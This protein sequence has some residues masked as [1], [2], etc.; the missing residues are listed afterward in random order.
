MQT[1]SLNIKS[2][3]IE[4]RPREKLAAKGRKSLT[5]VELLAI[6]IG[7][8]TGNRT[9][10]DLARDI[11]NLVQGNLN[12]LGKLTIA[13]LKTVKGIGEQKAIIILATLEL[14]ARKSKT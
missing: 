5:D 3:A 1:P 10:V 7:Q 9:A 12:E 13:Q 11:L 2:W 8:G 4:D 6:V 14:G